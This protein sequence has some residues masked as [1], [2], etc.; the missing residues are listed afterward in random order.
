MKMFVLTSDKYQFLLKSY[1]ELFNKNWSKDIEVVLLGYKK[2]KEELP[3]NFEFVS[4][5]KDSKSTP[6]S[7]K[8]IDFFN[9]IEDEYFFLCFEDH[10]L[11]QKGDIELFQ[12]GGKFIVPCPRFE[13]IG[14]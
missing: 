10:F 1:C 11:I 2:P 13:V 12:E 14:L 9:K 3:S 8:L 5:G 6:W 7:N 4:L